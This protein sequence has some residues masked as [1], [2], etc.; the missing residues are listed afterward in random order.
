MSEQYRSQRQFTFVL[1]EFGGPVHAVIDGDVAYNV[2]ADGT[3]GPGGNAA[4]R[5]V[6]MLRHPITIL[7]AALEEGAMV[8]PVRQDGDA[9]VVDITTA[10]G[11]ELALAVDRATK[12]PRSVSTMTFNG[13]LGDVA[14]VT[15]F[16]DYEDVDGG[17]DAA[18]AS[19]DNRRREIRVP[20]A[21][22]RCGDEHVGRRLEPPRGS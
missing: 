4:A 9:D 2:A 12:R 21:R 6:E 11:H 14:V 16:L 13:L 18:Q 1:P 10:K 5:Q 22:D 8:G 17:C 19:P 7:R 15:S 3:A 20:A